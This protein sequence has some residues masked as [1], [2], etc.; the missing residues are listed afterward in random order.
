M[1]CYNGLPSALPL[2]ALDPL[3]ASLRA[4]FQF[5]LSLAD[6]FISFGGGGISATSLSLASARR[7]RGATT[8]EERRSKGVQLVQTKTGYL[9]N[10]ETFKVSYASSVRNH[11]L[12]TTHHQV[13]IPDL[14]PKD[15]AA[16][17][18]YPSDVDS[19][20]WNAIEVRTQL[21][22]NF[23]KNL[24]VPSPF[25]QST[26]TKI[27]STPDHNTLGVL[28]RRSDG[29]KVVVYRYCKGER[30]DVDE[31]RE[32]GRDDGTADSQAD[33]PC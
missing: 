5:C 14:V 29:C 19:V 17:A 4:S 13:E 23:S 25:N 21:R 15:S 28:S 6:S 24:Q 3:V 22:W 1:S 8:K 31:Q 20:S 9:P 10:E 7:F 11:K 32:K 18:A 12:G 27:V 26:G 16:D 30:G 2:H 33:E